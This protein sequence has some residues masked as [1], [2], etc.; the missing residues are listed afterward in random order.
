MWSWGQKERSGN[1]ISKAPAE[2]WQTYMPGQNCPMTSHRES[3]KKWSFLDLLDRSWEVWGGNK[4]FFVGAPTPS[5]HWPS[6]SFAWLCLALIT[7]SRQL[8]F[9]CF[10]GPR[11]RHMEVPR[12]GIKSELQLTAYATATAMQDPSLIW[13]SRQLLVNKWESSFAI[14]S[15]HSMHYYWHW[16]VS[17]EEAKECGIGIHLTKRMPGEHIQYKCC[18]ASFPKR[19]SW[20]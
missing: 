4:C 1:G 3:P 12:L 18:K 10:L 17:S 13:D 16:K 15:H 8:F 2:D 7:S 5:L 20:F 6:D 11:L 14:R 19:V 9:F